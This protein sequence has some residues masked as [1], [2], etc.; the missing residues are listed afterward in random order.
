MTSSQGQSISATVDKERCLGA[1]LAVGTKIMNGKFN[2]K[3]FAYWH[4]DANAGCGWNEDAG[5]EGSPVIFHRIADR[6]L[7]GVERRAFF[8][9]INEK[10][11]IQLSRRF[12]GTPWARCSHI[13]HGDN[14]EGLE[15]FAECIRQSRE[16]SEMACGSV[17][18]DPNGYFYKS[19]K[20]IGAPTRGLVEFAAEF[21]RIDLILN[22]NV[23]TFWLQHGAGHAV[24]PPTEVL[25]SLNKKCW[26]VRFTNYSGH[27]FLLAVGRNV[28]TSPHAAIGFFTLESEGG[29]EVMSIADNDKDAPETIERHRQMELFHAR[30]V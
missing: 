20:G 17:L 11:I 22:L 26:L 6:Y 23:R 25:D 3:G 30:S 14:E 15:V 16:R 7:T 29:K 24:I 9:D 1:A 19:A 27:K 28:K 13:L 18:V 12:E 4:F 2:G 10:V 21:P 8:C 5:V